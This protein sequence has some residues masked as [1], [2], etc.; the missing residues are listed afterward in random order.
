MLFLACQYNSSAKIISGLRFTRLS[1]PS[2]PAQ[3]ISKN[4]FRF[5]VYQAFI[6]I[7]AKN[8]IV[9][10][11]KALYIPVCVV[12]EIYRAKKV[13]GGIADASKVTKNYINNL[14]IVGLRG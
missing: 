6:T 7:N 11:T 10:P 2:V 4:H 12:K 13:V 14:R 1:L 8:D 3:F 5:K 9:L